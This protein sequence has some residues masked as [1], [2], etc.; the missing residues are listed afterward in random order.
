MMKRH[1][2]DDGDYGIARRRR[3][4]GKKRH[5]GNVKVTVHWQSSSEVGL[6]FYQYKKE[7]GR[8]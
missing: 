3:E 8:K 7:N 1:D 2:D 5:K 6:T 4:I